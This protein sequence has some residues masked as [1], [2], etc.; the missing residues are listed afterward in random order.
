MYPGLLY[1]A[2]CHF[3]AIAIPALVAYPVPNGPVVASTPAVH[4][5][6][7]WPGVLES[8]CR[9]L[10]RSSSA[11]DGSPN[12]SYFGFTDRTPVRCSNEYNN[13]DA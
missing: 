2:A 3:E 5:Y 4:R 12:V 11:T 6:S 13:V 9:N 10:L 7:G 8:S 1:V